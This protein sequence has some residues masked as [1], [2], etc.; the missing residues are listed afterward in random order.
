MPGA[1][2][3]LL[4]NKWRV[5]GSYTEDGN[6]FV[7]FRPLPTMIILVK[8]TKQLF[9]G[10]LM[11][12]SNALHLSQLRVVVL[13]KCILHHCKETPFVFNLTWMALAFIGCFTNSHFVLC[14]DLDLL[15]LVT[16][17]LNS[18]LKQPQTISCQNCVV[19]YL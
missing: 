16:V 5:V 18:H 10:V 13:L 8:E 12:V 3:T 11:R 15:V 4:H 6:C 7:F 19:N 2:Y 1:F 9:S 17:C 14:R